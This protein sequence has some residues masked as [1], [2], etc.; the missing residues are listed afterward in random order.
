MTE[1]KKEETI[2][3][4]AKHT[5]DECTRGIMALE[6]TLYVIGGKW[7]LKIINALRTGGSSR[8]NQLQQTVTGISARILSKELKE[9][10]LNGFVKRKV[11]TDTP[12]VVIYEITPYSDTLETLLNEMIKWG[13]THK[14]KIRK[15][16]KKEL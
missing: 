12:V 2:S 1:L 8:F 15:E 16:Y 6:D 14:D 7:K 3:C 10:E 13:T 11:Y 5:P 9:L 4:N